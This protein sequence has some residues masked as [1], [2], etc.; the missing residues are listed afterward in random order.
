M[1]AMPGARHS[2][3]A[4]TAQMP[5]VQGPGVLETAYQPLPPWHDAPS[6]YWRTTP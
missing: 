1:R 2:D 5:E 6:G 4:V 3:T